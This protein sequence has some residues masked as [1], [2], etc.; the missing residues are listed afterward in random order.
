MQIS[1]KFKFLNSLTVR[2]IRQL[3]A[4]AFGEVFEGKWKGIHVAVKK[5]LGTRSDVAINEFF[6]EAELMK[7]MK[8]HPNVT[9]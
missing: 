7:Q 5:L 2:L 3:G 6:A 4:G 1:S 8:P 9:M